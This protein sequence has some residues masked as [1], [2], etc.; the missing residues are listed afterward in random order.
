M[1]YIKWQ[2]MLAITY[3]METCTLVIESILEQ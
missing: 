3:T 1:S 2:Q